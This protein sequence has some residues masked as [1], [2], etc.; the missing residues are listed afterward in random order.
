MIM[1]SS[2]EVHGPAPIPTVTEFR[3]PPESSEP[4][5]YSIEK[6]IFLLLYRSQGFKTYRSTIKRR[7]KEFD[8]RSQ[9]LQTAMLWFSQEPRQAG[10]CQLLSIENQVT[11]THTPVKLRTIKP[12][13]HTRH[14]ALKPD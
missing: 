11:C 3:L 5:S 8:M 14:C 9:N 7:K 6:W 13:I 10:D 1:E 4:C 12:P 2:L